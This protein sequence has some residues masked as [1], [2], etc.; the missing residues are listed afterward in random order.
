MFTFK[1]VGYK[2]ILDIPELEI[3]SGKT[4]C[5]VGE[6]GGGK[7][8]LIKLLNHLIS[9][10]TGEICYK[11][12]NLKDLDPIELRREVVM[13]SQN[14]VIFPGTIKDNL[15]MG[16]QFSEK[17]FVSDE[18]LL[19]VLQ[20]VKLNKN[21]SA[22]ASEM[23]GGEKQRLALARIILMDP[24]VLIL[25]EPSSALDEDTE[26]FII[27]KVVSFIRAKKKTL[28]M[29]THSRN[30]ART[31]GDI[32]VTIDKGKVLKVEASQ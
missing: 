5:I 2:N 13:L 32:T 11:G 31:Y 18:E 8:T 20:T 22:E 7:T 27:D 4:I 26:N 10:D 3:P 23:S 30:L 25:D 21:L 16:L 29:V 17:P 12:K 14:P 15:L 28:I 1:K 24:E 9:C 6:S 19:R